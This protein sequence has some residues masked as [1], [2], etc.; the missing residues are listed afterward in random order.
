MSEKELMK[1]EE[2][3]LAV[4]QEQDAFFAD[5][6][7]EDFNV[8]FTRVLADI[9]SP[10]KD[11]TH[12]AGLI[13]CTGSGEA[14]ADMNIVLVRPPEKTITVKTSDGEFVASFPYTRD[15]MEELTTHQDG[16]KREDADGNSIYETMN[17]YILNVDSGELSILPML[18]SNYSVA[19]AWN[20]RIRMKKNLSPSE[21]IWNISTKEKPYKKSTYW[22]FDIP[23]FIGKVDEDQAELVQDAKE[24]L[25]DAK[26]DHSKAHEAEP[27][28]DSSY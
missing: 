9:S 17:Y 10:V 27:A 16:L 26:V 21:M 13:Y 5:M 7:K 15:K 24:M 19:K 25:Q 18:S 4:K 6:G 22:S 20:T 8:P 23:K 12:A 2:Q 11:G 14:V 28:D 3:A 1:Q